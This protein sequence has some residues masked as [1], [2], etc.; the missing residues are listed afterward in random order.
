MSAIQ[1]S[2]TDFHRVEVENCDEHVVDKN[3][4]YTR[5]MFYDAED[6]E[7]LTLHLHYKDTAINTLMATEE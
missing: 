6:A 2:V 5:V 3:R 4:H 7:V 1:I